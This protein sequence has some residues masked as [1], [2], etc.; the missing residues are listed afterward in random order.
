MPPSNSLEPPNESAVAEA[1]TKPSFK[2]WFAGISAYKET[3]MKSF[4]KPSNRGLLSL[5][6]SQWPACSVVPA[7]CSQAI[8]VCPDGSRLPAPRWRQALQQQR[9]QLERERLELDRQR[10]KQAKTTSEAKSGRA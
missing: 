2:A 5:T 1:A 7:P 8:G 10:A 4:F 3:V 9:L 6:R